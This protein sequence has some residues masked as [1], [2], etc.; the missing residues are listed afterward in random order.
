MY[1][2]NLIKMRFFFIIILLKSIVGFSQ[3]YCGFERRQTEIETKDPKIK[4]AREK[5]ELNLLTL[6]RKKI[7]SKTNTTKNSKYVGPIYEIPV[8]VHVIESSDIN[9][10]SLALT[11]AQI[12]TW[13]ENTNKMFATTYGGEF[14]P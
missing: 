1:F 14:Y 11:D 10:A 5:A 2:K 8:V 12:E 9:N 4:I 3:E 7:L 6:N 13:I